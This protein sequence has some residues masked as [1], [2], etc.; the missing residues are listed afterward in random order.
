[1][2]T[3]Q[4]QYIGLLGIGDNYTYTFLYTYTFFHNVNYRFAIM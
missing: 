1:M 3:A 4:W 2:H